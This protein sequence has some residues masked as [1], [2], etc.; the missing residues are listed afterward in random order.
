MPEE[1]KNTNPVS[2]IE[3]YITAG[4]VFLLPLAVL[5]IFPN[6]F[7]TPK[8][9]ILVFLLVLLLAIK[10]LKIIQR[11]RVEIT[12]GSYDLPLILLAILYIVGALTRTPNRMEA[13]FLPGTTTFV[14]AGVVL[15][16][17]VNQLNEAQRG[18][19]KSALVA[20]GA[21]FSL[22]SLMALAGIFGSDAFPV[23][24]RQNYFNTLGGPILG[25]MLLLTALPF[26]IFAA[27]RSNNAAIKALA[28]V[29]GVLMIFGLIVNVIN[30]LPGRPGSPR[31]A[32]F[33]TSWN[34]AIDA[35][36]AEPIFGVG[37]SN[38]LTAFNRFR[39]A[40]FNLS[41]NW[42]LRFST[43]RSYFLTMF[44]EG[45]LLVL[46]ALLLIAVKLVRDSVAY[47][48]T[49]NATNWSDFKPSLVATWLLVLL[50]IF[51]PSTLPILVLFFVLLALNST[52]Q[53]MTFNLTSQ[54]EKTDSFATRFP[55]ILV[56]IPMILFAGAVAVYGVRYLSAEQTYYRA[57]TALARNEGAASYDLLRA[58]IQTNPLVDRYHGTY[59]QVNLALANAIAG[60]EDITDEDRQTIAQLIQQAIREGKATVSLN[61]TRAGNWELLA[62][63]YR[64]V[65]PLAQGADQFAVQTYNQAIALDPLNTNYRIALGGILYAAK[66]YDA[67]IDVFKLAV[68]TKPDHANAH[69]NLAMAFK[70]AGD[71][72]LAIQQLTTVLSLVPRDSE[73]YE[74]ARQQLEELQQGL[75][76]ATQEGG[77]LTAPGSDI[78]QPA[79]DPQ[80]ELPDDAQ[81]PAGPEVGEEEEV[82]GDEQPQESASP[83]PSASASPSATPLP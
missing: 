40:E 9:A 64:A 44:T 31:L 14:I 46:G 17:V 25:L 18:I 16:F 79:L 41:D 38:Y 15:Y 3:T 75:E 12:T 50:M 63:T 71:S 32:D 72:E 34:V 27:V 54:S 23:V 49:V 35:F 67:A 24:M 59:T 37:P 53:N 28:A 58:A 29:A 26:A 13:F 19:V 55:A 33:G 30:A 69:Y 48:R 65:I 74:V 62:S 61:P 52:R 80:L 57:L 7:D 82:G 66:Q 68:L 20:S 60:K 47:A 10:A 45:G 2:I 5:P 51:F 8:I 11:G 56:A 42:T 43:A 1:T 22:I 36:K 78:D 81:P 76:A 39:P 4:I 73:D 83:S 21:V 70:E 77:D 6:I